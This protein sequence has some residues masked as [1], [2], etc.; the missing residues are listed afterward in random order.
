MG[1]IANAELL[2][3]EHLQMWTFTD[4]AARVIAGVIDCALARGLHGTVPHIVLLWSLLAGERKLGVVV[5][6]A[7]GMNLDET[8]LRVS[9][10]IDSVTTLEGDDFDFAAI[11]ALAQDARELSGALKC[12]Y[13]GT[14]HLVLALCRSPDALVRDAFGAANITYDLYLRTVKDIL[15]HA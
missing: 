5:L 6:E 4:N 15:D 2:R 14:E 1:K 7:C 10:Q 11:V 12:S 13:V 8:R 9:Q 3:R